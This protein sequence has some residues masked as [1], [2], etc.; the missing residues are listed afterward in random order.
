MAKK[1]TDSGVYRVTEIIGTSDF[2]GRRREDAVE[3][4]AKSL[5]TWHRRSRQADLKVEGG[6]RLPRPRVTLV[7]VRRLNQT[8]DSTCVLSPPVREPA[9]GAG[10]ACKAEQDTWQHRADASRKGPAQAPVQAAA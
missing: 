1:K 8:S 4:A 9:H 2:M 10:A 6:R 5:R 7:Q 3:T